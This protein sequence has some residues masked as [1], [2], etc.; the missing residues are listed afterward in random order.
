MLDW[1]IVVPAF[2]TATVEWVEAFT[3]VLAVSLSI[4]WRAA[5]GAALAALAALAVMTALTGGV[6]GLGLDIRWLQLA[7][8]VFLLL[9]G[10]RWLAK[11]IARGAG[12]KALHDEAQEFADTRAALLQGEWTA[13]WLIAFKGVLLEGLEVWLVVVALGLHGRAWISSTAGALAAL[14]VVIV[15]GLAVRAPLQRVPENAIKFAVGAMITAFGTFWSLEAIGGDAAWP[16]GDLS[17]LLLAAFYSLGGLAL[18]ALLRTRRTTG[19]VQ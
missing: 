16:W 4:G 15:A 6:L 8:G 5:A 11:A 12:L 13:S 3:I 9:F 1:T 17:L 18:M 2:L 7:V 14:L 10:V 19:A